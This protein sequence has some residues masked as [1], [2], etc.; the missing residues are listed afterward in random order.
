MKVNKWNAQT[1][2]LLSLMS[3][4]IILLNGIVKKKRIISVAA[5]NLIDT[6]A[7]RIIKCF[8][9]IHKPLENQ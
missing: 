1:R 8:V 7:A 3:V 4:T 5:V 9:V 2:Y 6:V